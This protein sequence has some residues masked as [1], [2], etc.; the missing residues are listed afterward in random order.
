MCRPS[1]EPR[2]KR[3]TFECRRGPN[4]RKTTVLIPLWQGV[5]ALGGVED[6]DMHRRV[7]YGNRES[8]GVSVMEQSAPAEQ[9][10]TERVGKGVTERRR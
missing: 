6:L 8:L 7:M 1:I 10:S 2:N 9:S 4:A 3:A 5:E